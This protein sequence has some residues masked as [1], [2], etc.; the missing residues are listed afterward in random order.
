MDAAGSRDRPAFLRSIDAV[1]AWDF[2]RIAMG[3]GELV[4]KNAK[5]MFVEALRERELY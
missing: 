5:Q 3:H 2:D 4:T 1:L